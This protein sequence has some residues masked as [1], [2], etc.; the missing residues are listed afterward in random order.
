MTE[1]YDPRE[2]LRSVIGTKKA[3]NPDS[4]D[5]ADV[6][7]FTNEGFTYNIPIYLS[8]ESASLEEPPFP[9][10]DINL[11][12]VT[13]DPNDIEAKWRKHK[14]HLDVGVWFTVSD[15]Y[16]ASVFGKALLDELV[17]QVRTKQLACGFGGD[18]F[19]NIQ[20]ISLKR[21]GSGRQVVYHY[22]VEIFFTYYD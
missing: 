11:M 9:F 6:I 22:V 21:E 17:N 4:W 12:N 8:E 16:T 3:V 1:S 18:H 10:I 20:N 15:N 5:E 14:A 7:T 13:Y 2:L 19:A